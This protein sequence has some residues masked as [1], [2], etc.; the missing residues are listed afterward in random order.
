MARSR[1]KPVPKPSRFG[2]GQWNALVP[3]MDLLNHEFRPAGKELFHSNVFVNGRLEMYAERSFAL[4]EEVTWEYGPKPN[5]HLAQLYGFV[6]ADNPHNYLVI[7]VPMPDDDL[8]AL[9]STLLQELGG[10]PREGDA[11]RTCRTR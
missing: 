9:R 4:H 1:S 7:Q 3:L 6:V 10:G 5:I 8:K 11:C 2:D